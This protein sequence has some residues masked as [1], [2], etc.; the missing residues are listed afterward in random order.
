[1][2]DIDDV[3]QAVRALRSELTTRFELDQ[4]TGEPTKRRRLTKDDVLAAHLAAL[5]K[6]AVD[7][8]AVTIKSNS[9]GETQV[10]VTVRTDANIG[11]ETPAQAF[12][13]ASRIYIQAR[14]AFNMAGIPVT[15]SPGLDDGRQT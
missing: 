10:E 3:F 12:A 6:P 5:A 9:K 11:I 7:H 2:A 14:Q 13:E 1:M 15:P 4:T 8:H